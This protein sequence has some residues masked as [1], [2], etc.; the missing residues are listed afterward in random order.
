MRMSKG[1]SE[2]LVAAPYL[3]DSICASECDVQNNGEPA[4]RSDPDLAQLVRTSLAIE[5]Q[6]DRIN[7]LKSQHI[8]PITATKAAQLAP[9]TQNRIPLLADATTTRKTAQ[10]RRADRPVRP[11]R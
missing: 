8:A 11:E 1:A 4:F 10:V 9:L 6:P 2:L 7:R 5:C 3:R